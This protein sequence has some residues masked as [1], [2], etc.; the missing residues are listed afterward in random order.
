MIRIYNEM[1]IDALVM[2]QKKQKYFQATRILCSIN[3]QVHNAEKKPKEGLSGLKRALAYILNRKIKQK[4]FCIFF[5]Q[6]P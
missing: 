6:K 4:H 1:R 5:T 3:S 2:A